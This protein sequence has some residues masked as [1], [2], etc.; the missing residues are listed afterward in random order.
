MTENTKLELTWIGKNKPIIVEPRILIENIKMSNNKEDTN[1]MLIHGDNLLA[2]K[3]LENI[4]GGEIKCIYID[5]PYNTGA[6]FELYDDNLEHSIWLNLMKERLIILKNLLTENGIIYVQIDKTEQA[7]LKVLMDEIFGRK[8]FITMITCKVTSPGGL[9]GGTEMFFDS[10]EYVLCYAYNKEKVEFNS[11]KVEAGVMGVAQFGYDYFIKQINYDAKKF[12]KEEGGIKYYSIDSNN[13]EF[14]KI[15]KES[16]TSQFYYENFHNLFQT[17]NLSGGIGKKLKSATSDLDSSNNLIICNYVPSKG[18]RKGLET[19]LLMWKKRI[20]YTLDGYVQADKSK[21]QVSKLDYVTNI[22]TDSLW[23]G[24]ASEGSVVFNNGKKPERFIKVLLDIATN[25]GDYVLDSFLGSGT[26]CAVA[27]KMGRKW[28]G[29]EMGDHAYTHC[30]TRLDKIIEGTDSSG[31]TS[32]V[33]WIGGGG[34]RFY[35]LAPTLIKK[36]AFDQEI[37]NPDYNG[38]M[39]SSAVAIHEGYTYNPNKECY[40]KQSY[41]GEKSYLYVTTNHIGK[42]DIDSIK[43]ELKDD[44]Y[45]IIVCKS[46]DSN[47]LEGIKNI[48][49]KK[50]PQSLLKNCEFD[51]EN[52]NLNIINPPIYDEDGDDNE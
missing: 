17:A 46:Y 28:I 18:K 31:I 43:T 7:Y 20:I 22:F 47:S 14:V 48:G 30:K 36:D 37:I 15:P 39:L 29:I 4:H 10:S 50:I 13:F 2:L 1:N 49:I 52:Y 41:N 27:N 25:V 19:N 23:N 33:N 8:N 26:T 32:I 51:V 24:I 16:L 38:E 45:L 11:I 5:P 44:E 35:E 40:W 34:Y 12:I 42:R 3:A 21:K 9:T 6:A